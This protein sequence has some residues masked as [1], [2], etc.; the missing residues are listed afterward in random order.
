MN[1]VDHAEVVEVRR[2]SRRYGDGETAVHALREVSLSL[3]AGELSLLFG[4]SGSGKTTLLQI[5]G[6]LL[7]PSD[8]EVRLLQQQVTGCDE[9]QMAALRRQH[10]GFVFQHYNLLTAL[11]VWEN[12][13]IAR[14][15]V[16]SAGALRRHADEAYTLL[17]Q[18]GLGGLEMRFPNQLSG[19]QKQRVAIARAMLTK[20][21]L[22]LADEPT[23]ALDAVAGRRVAAV[24]NAL[25]HVRGCAVVVVTHD[26][27]LIPF[28]D[29]VLTLADGELVSDQ[30][31][32]ANGQMRPYSLVSAPSNR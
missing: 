7:H 5:L 31:V 15:V 12:V 18:L 29:R 14:S 8:G 1:A 4:P 23:A 22:L 11:R 3:R 32:A 2:V 28:A 6:A 20:P 10:C 17:R 30:R 25:A 16:D 24:L 13:A 21:R 27:R 26:R 9:E 19:G